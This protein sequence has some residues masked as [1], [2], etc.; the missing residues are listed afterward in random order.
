M[1]PDQAAEQRPRLRPWSRLRGGRL[2]SRLLGRVSGRRRLQVQPPGPVHPWTPPRSTPTRSVRPPIRPKHS[3]TTDTAILWPTC[4]GARRRPYCARDDGRLAR[5]SVLS[6]T[7]P[8]RATRCY[9]CGCGRE[10][11]G[12]PVGPPTT[13]GCTSPVPGSCDTTAHICRVHPRAGLGVGGEAGLPA[14]WAVPT[15]PV[16]PAPAV[17]ET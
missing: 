17:D 2:Q 3:S 7:S 10:P 4:H 9:A 15:V 13:C 12:W 16:W 6:E 5:A 11:R 1:S 14:S 8:R